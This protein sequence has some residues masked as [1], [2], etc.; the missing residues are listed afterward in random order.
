MKKPRDY[1]PGRLLKSS[2]L[3][4]L[5]LQHFSQLGRALARIPKQ[6][7]DQAREAQRARLQAVRMLL[8]NHAGDDP[9]KAAEALIKLDAGG[10]TARA[11][12]A[13]EGCGDRPR[14]E[15]HTANPATIQREICCRTI[16]Y[17][18]TT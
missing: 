11:R 15:R 5:S 3:L 17:F 14:R 13:D 9:I 10:A 8:W 6:E 4:E 2:C 12:H 18:A 16:A 7:A 1:S